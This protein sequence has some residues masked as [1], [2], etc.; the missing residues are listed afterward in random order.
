MWQWWLFVPVL[1]VALTWSL[2]NLPIRPERRG[3]DR[4]WGT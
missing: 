2:C 4:P 1:L 3:E